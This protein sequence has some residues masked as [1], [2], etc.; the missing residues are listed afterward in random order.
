[1]DEK[2]LSG[3][4]LLPYIRAVLFA[5][6]AIITW[7]FACAFLVPKVVQI[8]D[9]AGLRPEQTEWLWGVTFFLVAYGKTILLAALIAAA[10]G[11]W[12]TRRKPRWKGAFS[13]TIAWLV[14]LAVLFGLA[15]LLI[16]ALIAAPALAHPK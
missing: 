5:L 16:L 4:G 6:P 13:T 3:P 1:M 12:I 7:G 8:A 9:Q 15:C 10:L 14:N 11:E 2:P